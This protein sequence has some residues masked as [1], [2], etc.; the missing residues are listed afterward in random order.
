M[1][2][3]GSLPLCKLLLIHIVDA[4]LAAAAAAL[5]R[6][7]FLGPQS[8]PVL[9]AATHCLQNTSP[10]SNPARWKAARAH[11]LGVFGEGL[12]KSLL[13]I[14]HVYQTESLELICVCNT[15][16]S[17]ECSMPGAEMPDRAVTSPEQSLSPASGPPPQPGCP[18][19]LTPFNP[20]HSAVVISY[21]A[22]WSP[23]AETS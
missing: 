18:A 11:Q 6:R 10:A 22:A 7:R 17:L 14:L 23:G 19:K 13:S 1:H 20:A 12:R 21:K 16:F 9:L 3:F 5:G 15:P 8:Q 2:C 4:G